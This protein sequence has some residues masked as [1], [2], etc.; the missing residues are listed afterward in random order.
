MLCWGVGGAV[1]RCG[2]GVWTRSAE[3]GAEVFVHRC[4]RSS[5]RART[6]NGRSAACTGRLRKEQRSTASYCDEQRKERSRILSDA[7]TT[8][9]AGAHT[10]TRHRRRP[11]PHSLHTIC[12]KSA[13]LSQAGLRTP[14]FIFT[15]AHLHNLH[16][17]H[18]TLARFHVCRT[19]RKPKKRRRS[20]R[21]EYT[22]R[23]APHG[24]HPRWESAAVASALASALDLVR[25]SSGVPGRCLCVLRSP[26][27]FISR[28]H[29]ASFRVASLL[30]TLSILSILSIFVSPFSIVRAPRG[31][32]SLSFFLF[33]FFLFYLNMPHFPLSLLSGRSWTDR[34]TGLSHVLIVVGH[35]GPA[36]AHGQRRKWCACRLPIHLIRPALFVTML[37]LECLAC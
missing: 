20:K 7:Q 13:A 36:P 15:L 17:T 6:T 29:N 18:Y 27:P 35:R 10:H 23:I 12:R 5:W 34:Q 2:G 33:F 9:K 22:T 16:A 14:H 11:F 25:L 21:D 4:G 28:P 8:S 19:R 32:V 37:R 26:V 3:E 24:H 30:L 31:S 1:A